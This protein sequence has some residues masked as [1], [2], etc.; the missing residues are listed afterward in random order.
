MYINEEHFEFLLKNV[1][2]AP[3]KLVLGKCKKYPKELYTPKN[4]SQTVFEFLNTDSRFLIYHSQIAETN[5]FS[6][7]G[8]MIST[9]T[10][11]QGSIEHCIDSFLIYKNIKRFATECK[12]CSSVISSTVLN[13][14]EKQ[15]NSF[16]LFKNVNPTYLFENRIVTKD[17]DIVIFTNLVCVNMFGAQKNIILENPESTFPLPNL[18][19]NESQVERIKN[20][21]ENLEIDSQNF[22]HT[23][24]C[25]KV[26]LDKNNFELQSIVYKIENELKQFCK[27]NNLVI[28]P[29]R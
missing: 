19:K 28:F 14:V 23:F 26:L 4:I 9:S 20:V 7:L 24:A 29:P 15:S 22:F 5:I 2:Y 3:L 10:F 12:K 8:K 1:E 18:I 17:I 21:F 13:F 11:K 25:Y 16:L 6:I 27:D